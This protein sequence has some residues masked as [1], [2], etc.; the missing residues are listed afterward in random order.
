MGLTK[1]LDCLSL[2]S[3]PIPPNRNP[4]TVSS[5]AMTDISLPM[6]ILKFSKIIFFS[7]DPSREF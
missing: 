7:R 1:K 3:S 5:S 6:A 2:S 4:V